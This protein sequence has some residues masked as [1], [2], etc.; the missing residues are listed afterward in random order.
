MDRQPSAPGASV[1]SEGSGN[2]GAL[3]FPVIKPSF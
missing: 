3:P 1:I 2:L